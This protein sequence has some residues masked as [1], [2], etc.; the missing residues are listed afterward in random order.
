MTDIGRVIPT[1][2]GDRV[3]RPWVKLRGYGLYGVD[4]PKGAFPLLFWYMCGIY[5][6]YGFYL[7]GELLLPAIA[8][9]A[10]LFVIL[11]ARALALL[12]GCKLAGLFEYPTVVVGVSGG[13]VLSKC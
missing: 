5:H 1:I 12:L 7:R 11:I 2:E 6:V 9:A 10:R 13:L 3:S 8:W 4:L